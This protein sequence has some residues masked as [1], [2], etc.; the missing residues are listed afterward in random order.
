[1]APAGRQFFL[2]CNAFLDNEKASRSKVLQGY[3]A[4]HQV[5][6]HEFLR[7]NL[8]RIEQNLRQADRLIPRLVSAARPINGQG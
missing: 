1:M 4:L 5:F 6:L 3:P 7:L 8:H 2:L